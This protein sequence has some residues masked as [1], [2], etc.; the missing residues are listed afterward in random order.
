MRDEVY[1]E[2][3]PRGRTSANRWCATNGTQVV[4]IRNPYG[5]VIRRS[6]HHADGREYVLVYVDER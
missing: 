6:Q 3:L 4:T 2:D 5:D 1:Y